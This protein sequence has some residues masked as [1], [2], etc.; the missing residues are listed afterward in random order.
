[1]N[2]EKLFAGQGAIVTGAGTGIG[3]E[4]AR[5]LAARGARVLLNDIDAQ[6][7]RSAA[8]AISAEG[9]V[10]EPCAGNVADVAFNREMVERA[11]ALFGRLDIAV[12]NAG[13]TIFGDF[14]EYRPEDFD[15]LL[16]INLRGSF[17][18]AQAA[19]RRM[20]A[21]GEG[22]RILFM[23]SVTAHQAHSSLAAYGMSKAGIEMLARALT[24]DLGAYGITVNAIAP[25]ATLT[26]RT[27]LEMDDYAGEW[28][29]F[30]PTRRVSTPEDIAQAVVF[31]CSPGARQITGQTIL[32]DGGWTTTSPRPK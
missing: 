4:I 28:A 21:Q 16:A 18:L 30:I 11:V 17:F 5:Q 9:S 27:A 23:S 15:R 6:R 31:L 12:A 8:A 19:A 7:A 3:F 26:E 10:C 32:V 2:E 1:M 29:K 14:F 24:E 20:R 22:G 13:V 25:G